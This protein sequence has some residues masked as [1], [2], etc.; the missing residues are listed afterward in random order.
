MSERS[1]CRRVVEAGSVW[2][3]YAAVLSAVAVLGVGGCA[4]DDGSDMLPEHTLRTQHQAVLMDDLE[5]IG[6]PYPDNLI[7]GL[8]RQL[9]DEINCIQPGIL[10]PV[11]S[12]QEVGYLYTTRN[13][14]MLMRPEVKVAAEGVALLYNDYLTIR[15]TYRDVGMQYFDWYWGQ[16]LSFAAARPG[17]SN[18]Q[19]GQAMD[20]EYHAFWRQRLIDYGWSW[21]YGDADQPHFEWIRNNTPDLKVESVR[22]FQRLWNRNNPNDPIGED[23]AWGPQTEARMQQTHAEG[24]VFG[25]CDIDRDGHA[26]AVIG[27][28]DCDD[29]RADVHPGSADVCGDGIDQDC[30]GGDRVCGQP[31]PE[32]TDTSGGGTDI[33]TSSG[34]DTSTAA[35]TSS[36]PDT[37]TPD[38]S[39][40]TAADTSTTID[41]STSGL[42]SDTSSSGATTSPDAASSD[43]SSPTIPPRVA[44]AAP[45]D[46][47]QCSSLRT[48]NARPLSLP[49]SVLLGFAAAGAAVLRRTRRR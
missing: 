49:L 42:S 13:V 1:A 22:A 43:T 39:T 25:G 8:S 36:T 37:S 16:R 24:F 19:G 15:S 45:E 38:T 40:T 9:V 18:H 7:F 27:G 10:V 48:H 44:A 46:D 34:S 47:C 31:D 11:E 17:A 21:P 32:P 3:R 6:G 33:S 35:D 20:V 30:A 2:A 5:W 12:R 4:E 28:D 23:G 29:A 14:P 41:A 26:A